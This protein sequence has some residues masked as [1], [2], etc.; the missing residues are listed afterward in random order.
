MQMH[1]SPS[2]DFD[3]CDDQSMIGSSDHKED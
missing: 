2:K 1:D 3:W